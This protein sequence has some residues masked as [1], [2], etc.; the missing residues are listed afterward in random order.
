M[1][2]HEHT[3]TIKWLTIDQAFLFC[4]EHQLPRTKKTIR[5][6]CRQGHVSGQK[7]TTQTGERWVLDEASL[8]VKVEAEKQMMVSFSSPPMNEQVQTGSNP[9]EPLASNGFQ[10]TQS[11]PVQTGADQF[12]QVRTSADPFEPVLAE[13]ISELE[14][15][16]RSLEIDKAVRDKHVEFLSKQNA[17][18]QKNLLSQS[19]YIGH[20]ETQV[21][22]L[23]GEPNE[24]FLKA[25]TANETPSVE[26]QNPAQTQFHAS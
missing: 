25:P 10:Q 6:W 11:E 7:Q 24:R 2:T 14:S 9:S 21:L 4:Q 17:E 23:G 19:R 12:E 5:S 16:V 13:Q 8:L 15:K 26:T 18:G 3:Q 22:Q 20:L 1:N